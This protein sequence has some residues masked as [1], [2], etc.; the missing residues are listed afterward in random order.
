VTHVVFREDGQ[1]RAIG[2][3]IACETCGAEFPVESVL[4]VEHREKDTR[5]A[6]THPPGHK[7]SFVTE[8]AGAIALFILCSRR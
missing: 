3:T 5:L 4:Q 1:P 2:G 6:I 7:V 8:G